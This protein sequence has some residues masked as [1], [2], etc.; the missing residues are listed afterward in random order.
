MNKRHPDK[1]TNVHQQRC[2]TA[3]SQVTV[4]F[5]MMFQPLNEFNNL[6]LP[7]TVEEVVELLYDDLS[8]RDKVVMA[9]LSENELDATVYLAMAKTIRREFGLY[10]GNP[11]LLESCC[12]YLGNEYDSYE[13]PAMVIMKEL[14]KKI[15][16][17]H[18]LR[19]VKKRRALA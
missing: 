8:L 17:S 18:N 12:R 11:E 14:W 10:N 7:G 13:D 19:L 16:K 9:H 2:V 6:N 5:A 4:R 3:F 1:R 15:R